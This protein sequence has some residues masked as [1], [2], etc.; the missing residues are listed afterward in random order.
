MSLCYHMRLLQANTFALGRLNWWIV[1]TGLVTSAGVRLQQHVVL[2]RWVAFK[3][4]RWR[5]PLYENPAIKY[6]FVSFAST[7]FSVK[8][9]V[10]QPIDFSLL[11][12]KRPTQNTPETSIFVASSRLCLAACDF[13]RMTW[14]QHRFA[15]RMRLRRLSASS[16]LQREGKK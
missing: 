3:A 8:N 16:G 6:S 15:C 9:G 7:L 10:R 14:M 4:G 2:R 13:Y 5:S 12:R 11:S 1:L